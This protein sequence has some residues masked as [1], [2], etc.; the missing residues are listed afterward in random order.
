M[1]H[2]TEAANSIIK[3]AALVV[4][5]IYLFRRFTEPTAVENGRAHQVAPLGR[6]IV[7]WSVVF[8][9]LSLIAGPVPTL[10][11]N[12][13]ILVALA[14]VLS[15]GVQISEDLQKGLGNTTA[16]KPTAG[17]GGKAAPAPSVTTP[18]PPP[19]ESSARSV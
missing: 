1:T 5:G 11:G 16:K 14:A 4:A 17:S 10:A 15:N 6:F 7:A 13:A 9:G 18:I 8:F 3:T 12:M 2:T 19:L